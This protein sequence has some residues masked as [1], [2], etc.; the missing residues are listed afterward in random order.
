[1]Q[2]KIVFEQLVSRGCGID[3]HKKVLVATIRG[4]GLKE[5]TRTYD[6][7]TEDIELPGAWLKSNEVTHVAMVRGD[8]FPRESLWIGKST[9]VY[10]KPVFN[11]LEADLEVILVNARHIKN[12]PKQTVNG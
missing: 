11:I 3:V 6:C 4:V 2:E 8:A 12:V 1:M 9:G 10:W 5:E 7:F